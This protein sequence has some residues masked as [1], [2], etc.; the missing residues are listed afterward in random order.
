MSSHLGHDEDTK[1]IHE[2]REQRGVSPTEPAALTS[3]E[4]GSDAEKRLLRK[5]DRRIVVRFTLLL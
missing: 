3:Y 4:P 1:D 5:I 2:W